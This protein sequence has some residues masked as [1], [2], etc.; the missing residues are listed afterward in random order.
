VPGES[1]PALRRRVARDGFAIVGTQSLDTSAIDDAAWSAQPARRMLDASWCRALAQSLA[2]VPAIAAVLPS[3]AVAVQCTRFEKST[4]RNWLVPRHQDLIVPV[5]ER[6][7]HRELHAWSTK[8]GGAHVQG[9]ASLL[10]RLIPVR[11]HL[12]ACG[13]GDGVLHVVPGSHRRGIVSDEEACVSR[14]AETPCCVPQGHVVIMRPLLLHRSAKASGASRRRVLH[15]VFG[16][17]HL[18]FGLRWPQSAF[19]PT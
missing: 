19:A 5:H 14:A 15:F 8:N 2:R 6:I 9:P 3:G 4:A 17:S 1:L 13:I 10:R 12:D 16:P 18:P 7:D 11:L